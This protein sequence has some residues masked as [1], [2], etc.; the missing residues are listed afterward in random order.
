MPKSNQVQHRSI[1]SKDAWNKARGESIL[2]EP[3]QGMST[4][5]SSGEDG[6]S[7]SMTSTPCQKEVAFE[8]L[9]VDEGSTT[10]DLR[11]FWDEDEFADELQWP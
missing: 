3:K 7:R 1:L 9:A 5:A 4:P 8:V 11:E 10:L 6:I 2:L